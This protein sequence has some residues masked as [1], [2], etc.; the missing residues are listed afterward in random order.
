[1]VHTSI[2][3]KIVI[4]LVVLAVLIGASS[5]YQRF[6]GMRE[7]APPEVQQVPGETKSVTLFFGNKGADGFLTEAREIPV[8]G[9]F[10]DQ[11]KGA[12]GELVK[13]PQGGEKVN[14]IPAGSE[15]LQVFWVEDTQTLF[16]DFNKALVANHPG[17]SAG[18]YFTIGSILKTVS[19][20]F[21]QV[22]KVQFLID[23]STV[24][25][26]A[27]HYAVDKPIEVQK[28]K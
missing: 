13:G 7:K 22:K 16:L 3:R 14:A 12:L 26:I 11:V 23:G 17:G 15:L 24:E 8:A 6:V 10:E 9:V 19:A 20:N 4:T 27:G 2:G 21:P 1:M 28:W 18:E 5:L 25:S